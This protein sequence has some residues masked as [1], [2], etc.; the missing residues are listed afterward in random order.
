MMSCNTP[1][2]YQPALLDLDRN[3]LPKPMLADSV[4]SLYG[5]SFS[6]T[7]SDY[8]IK[9]FSKADHQN[10]FE[11]NFTAS[12]LIKNIQVSY[13]TY[14]FEGEYE[15]G[16]LKQGS[17]DYFDRKNF[18]GYGIRAAINFVKADGDSELR[19]PGLELSYSKEEGAF[20]QYRSSLLNQDQNYTNPKT[21]LFTAGLFSETAWRS[22]RNPDFYFAAKLFFGHTFGDMSFHNSKSAHEL[23]HERTLR[24]SMNASFILGFKQFYLVTDISRL[25]AL[26]ITTGIALGKHLK[27][28]KQSF[29]KQ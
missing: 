7:T 11:F 23:P 26:K 16:A 4:K 1:L 3:Y 27:K 8:N 9:P 10:L 22:Y 2:Y 25:F 28:S 29:K 18:N 24:M 12:H 20:A 13:G 19:F 14:L 15:N 21:G 6:Y 5:I 17:T